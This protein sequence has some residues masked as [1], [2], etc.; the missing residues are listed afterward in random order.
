MM[1]RALGV[2]FLAVMLIQPAATGKGPSDVKEI[3]NGPHVLEALVWAMYGEAMAPWLRTR[4]LF[5]YNAIRPSRMSIGPF[6]RVMRTFS[7]CSQ[8][9]AFG[10][11]QKCANACDA[12]KESCDRQCSSARATCLDQ[13][14]GI[15]F[16][17]DFQC[18]AAYF[19][20]KPKCGRA[21]DACVFN[22]PTRG[23]EKE[24]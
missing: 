5:S 3:T 19:L 15:G 22:C 11:D 7:P 23:G 14:L 4:T 9:L 17:C 12:A 10:P 16:A 18:Q 1:T 2:C 20:C 24:S 8:T 13:C 21:H 6:D